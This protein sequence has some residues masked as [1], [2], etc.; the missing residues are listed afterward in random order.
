VS[1]PI[2]QK[3]WLNAQEAADYLEVKLATLYSYTSNRRIRFFKPG[4][5]LKFRISDLDAFLESGCVETLSQSLE[6]KQNGNTQKKGG[7]RQ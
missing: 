6:R 4:G 1:Y 7:S 5:I 2:V 3:C